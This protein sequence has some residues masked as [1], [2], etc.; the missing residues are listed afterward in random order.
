MAGSS[1]LGSCKLMALLCRRT[2]I[3]ESGR[4]KRRRQYGLRKLLLKLNIPRP[5]PCLNPIRLE[6]RNKTF[7][8]FAKIYERLVRR[9]ILA[10]IEKQLILGAFV[11]NQRHVRSV[12]SKDVIKGNQAAERADVG[13]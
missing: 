3:S 2:Y 1:E 11:R 6:I 4:P 8:S 9:A 13:Q 5:L 10:R 7:N 12:V